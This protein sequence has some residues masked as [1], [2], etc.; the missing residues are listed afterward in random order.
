MWT[1][2]I[3][4]RITSSDAFNASTMILCGSFRNW[5]VVAWLAH[6]NHKRDETFS[7][8]IWMRE[9][10]FCRSLFFMFS[11]D[12]QSEYR[13]VNKRVLMTYEHV[14]FDGASLKRSQTISQ[15][16]LR[17]FHRQYREIW[18][19]VCGRCETDKGAVF[20]LSDCRVPKQKK[21]FCV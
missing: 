7:I 13:L 8:P 6:I 14:N 4:R 10:C 11:K 20:E 19:T 9:I 16:P 12:N 5:V 3:K 21:A 17:D 2:Y 15:R 18:L 1:F